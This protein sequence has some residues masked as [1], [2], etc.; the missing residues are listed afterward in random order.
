MRIY[1]GVPVGARAGRV[2]ACFA[3]ALFAGA[4]MTASGQ[5]LR[6][7]DGLYY[8]DDRAEDDHF[9]WAIAMDGDVAVLGA[10]FEDGGGVAYV[11]RRA[12]DR[13]EFSQRLE[14]SDRAP[15]ARF[16]IDVAI[17]G[18]WIVVGAD[19]ADVAGESCGAAYVFAFDKGTR[20]FVEVQKLTSDDPDRYEE[21]GCSVAVH[22]DVIAVGEARV[23]SSSGTVYVFRIDGYD[24]ILEQKLERSDGY[25]QTGF[26]CK[27]A[28]GED[29]IAVGAADSVSGVAAYVFRYVG[30]VVGWLEEQKLTP[31][32]TRYLSVFSMSLALSGD[33]LLLGWP[34]ADGEAPFT[35][36]VYSFIYDPFLG[37]WFEAQK[38]VASD[39]DEDDDF[40]SAVALS[41]DVAIV[42]AR[43]DD[44]GCFLWQVDCGSAY[45]FRWDGGRWVLTRKLIAIYGAEGDAMGFA[46]AAAGGSALIGASEYDAP[47]GGSPVADTGAAYAFPTTELLLSVWPD[48][49]QA[50]RVVHFDTC[51]GQPGEPVVLALTELNGTVVFLHILSWVFNANCEFELEPTVPPGFEGLEMTFQV[52]KLSLRGEALASNAETLRVE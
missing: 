17:H 12:D 18:W 42:G 41:E 13:W 14:A 27:V 23:F 51:C 49:V 22:G 11:Y 26:G 3:F 48:V 36:A 19:S 9:G 1:R 24:C 8:P 46:A 50:G 5:C 31:S 38:L 34:H 25:G 45:L 6:F 29:V 20:R 44:D 32:D 2:V 30:E 21:F 40:G 4:G 33:R 28:V 39:G 7:P 37:R 47:S 10:P 16:G 43:S 35:G 15:R 52:F